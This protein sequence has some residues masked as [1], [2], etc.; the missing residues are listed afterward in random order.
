MSI[1]LLSA[2][3]LICIDVAS[4]AR[5]LP[6]TPPEPIIV[7]AAQ[8]ATTALKPAVT[9]AA[10]VTEASAE[11]E[12]AFDEPLVFEGESDTAVANKLIEYLE[13]IDTLNGDFTQI[14]PSGAISVGKFYLRRPGFLRFEY[15]PPT[16]LLLVANGG[17]VYVR[18]EALETTDSYPVGKTPLK[19]L[20][21]KVSLHKQISGFKKQYR[22]IRITNGGIF[23][24]QMP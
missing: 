24:G 17:M 11:D 1:A 8:D 16:P 6:I 7:A 20:L 15:E 23:T 13:N 21:S 12:A 22:K 4:A 18:D 19:F 9:S 2:L 5:P 14:A 10:P 3:S